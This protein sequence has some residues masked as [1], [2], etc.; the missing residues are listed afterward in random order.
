[1]RWKIFSFFKKFHFFS[2]FHT[3]E[4][5]A[6]LSHSCPLSRSAALKLHAKL[7]KLNKCRFLRKQESENAFLQVQYCQNWLVISWSLNWSQIGIN[8][9]VREHVCMTFVL[10]IRVNEDSSSCGRCGELVKL[11]QVFEN[12]SSLTCESEE[13]YAHWYV[14]EYTHTLELQGLISW[15]P[16]W[17]THTHTPQQLEK[18]TN[19]HDSSLLMPLPPTPMLPLL[20]SSFRLQQ[21]ERRREVEERKK[22]SRVALGSGGRSTEV[23]FPPTGCGCRQHHR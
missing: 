3:L 13:T 2:V 16:A 10:A 8:G 23:A 7:A 17:Q 11:F 14:Y 12:I 22:G 9:S 21:N 20:L 6:A 5:Y 1:M 15:T 4:A 18:R 19:M